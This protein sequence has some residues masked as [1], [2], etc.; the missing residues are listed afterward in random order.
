[1]NVT[2]PPVGGAFDNVVTMSASG[3]PP[4]ATATFNPPTVTPGS[5]GAPTVMTIQLASLTAKAADPHRNLTSFIFFFGLCGIG[6]GGKRFRRKSKRGLALLV[7]ALA[8]SSSLACGGGFLGPPTTRA[9]SYVVTIT[10]TSGA[11]HVSATVT[12]VVQ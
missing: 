5:A 4:G 7:L 6:F 12:V 2:V 10:G 11:A 9:G 1:M 3:L 8:A